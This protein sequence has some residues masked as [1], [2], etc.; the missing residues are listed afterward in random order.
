[1]RGNK[2]L[3]EGNLHHAPDGSRPASEAIPGALAAWAPDRPLPERAPGPE[4]ERIVVDEVM[5]TGSV[6]LLRAAYDPKGQGAFDIKCWKAEREEV[7]AGWRLEA[8]VGMKAPRTVQEG[9]VFFVADGSKLTPTYDPKGTPR[10]KARREHLLMDWTASRDFAR[11]QIK[12]E[13]AVLS[14]RSGTSAD[15]EA[16]RGLVRRASNSLEWKE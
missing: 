6:R 7:M 14:L 5:P 2:T 8:F 15:D 3:P 16:V 12:E 11:K 4:S 9:D 10:D 1:M 13:F